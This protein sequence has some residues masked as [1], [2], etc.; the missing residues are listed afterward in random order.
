LKNHS[1]GFA[2]PTPS[3]LFFKNVIYPAMSRKNAKLALLHYSAKLR[4]FHLPV[5]QVAFT[6]RVI[7]RARSLAATKKMLSLKL[8]YLLFATAKLL[9]GNRWKNITPENICCG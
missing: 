9:Y 5:I 1:Q 8:Q 7:R 3:S 4:A 6:F 2:C